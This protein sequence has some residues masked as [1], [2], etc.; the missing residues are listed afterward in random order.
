[1]GGFIAG[2]HTSCCF[3][4][5]WL[6]KIGLQVKFDTCLK[7]SIVYGLSRAITLESSCLIILIFRIYQKMGDYFFP[8]N[9]SSVSA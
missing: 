3:P 9:L 5:V 7:K 1:M 6:F 2:N 4:A 8:V